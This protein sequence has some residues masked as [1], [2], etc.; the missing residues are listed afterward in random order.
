MLSRDTIGLALNHC[1]DVAYLFTD[2]F[3]CQLLFCQIVAVAIRYWC[4]SAIS[5]SFV[6]DFK[7]NISVLDKSAGLREY[8]GAGGGALYCL[9]ILVLSIMVVCKVKQSN[10]AC[11]AEPVEF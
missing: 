6:Q 10:P 2:F 4:G 8:A 7:N 3:F 9:W 5:D 1:A 11:M